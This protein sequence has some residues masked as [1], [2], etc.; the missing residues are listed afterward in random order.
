MVILLSITIS[1]ILAFMCM[2][3]KSQMSH[4]LDKYA[5]KVYRSSSYGNQHNYVSHVSYFKL[6]NI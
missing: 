5:D 6:D 3:V 1:L 2:Y 4:I